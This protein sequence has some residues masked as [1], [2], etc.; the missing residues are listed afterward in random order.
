M[1]SRALNA[2]DVPR[3]YAELKR[4]VLA[5]VRKGRRDI[6]RAWLHTYHET[7]RLIHEHVL[8][9]KDR[10]AYGAQVYARLAADTG[11]D[12]RT[13]QQCV[14]FYRHF[15]IARHGA[16]LNWAHYRALVQVQDK[17]QREA[18]L[19]Q[20]TDNHWTSPELIERVRALNAID[21]T[22]NAGDSPGGV[23]PSPKPLVPKCGT[24]GVGRVVVSGA[25]LAVDLGFTSYVDLPAVTRLRDGEFV[26]LAADGRFAA[27]SDATK[28]DLYTYQAEILRVVDGDTLWVKIHLRPD[29]WI[30][31]KL[32]LRGLDCPEMNTAE[33]RA[34]KRF[35]EALV[36]RARAVTITTT[37][38]DK[39]DRYLSDVFLESGE[40]EMFLNNE[41][42]AQ[43]H[44]RRMD[45][46]ALTDWD[47][48]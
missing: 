25:G 11:I 1:P 41:L 15:P 31:E 5:A 46:Y 6:D 23:P 43:G 24:V 42:L 38:P 18:L 20:T 37:K 30:K 44:A 7:G 4:A 39:W 32:R 27:A 3:T 9:K 16:Q 36:T 13:L 12:K 28:A 10:A 40:G 14:Q 35:V 45:E 26:R 2:T 22:S 33:G 19:R 34:A 47:G 21:V 48:G 8:L 29:W 17:A